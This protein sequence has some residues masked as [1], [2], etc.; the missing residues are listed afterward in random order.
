[1]PNCLKAVFAIAILLSFAAPARAKSG[2]SLVLRRAEKAV[3]IDGLIDAAWS[4]AD[5][6]SDFVELQPFYGKPPSRRTVAKIMASDEA[7]YCLIICYDDRSHI[8]HFAGKLDEFTGDA[9]S[10]MF[11][12]F[13]DNR[14]A[15]KFAVGASGSR[16]D[17]RLL[18][19][20][21]NRDYSWDGVWFSAARI[22]NWGYVVEM[23]IPFRSIQYD[24]RLAAW[25]LDFDRWIPGSNEDI[26]WNSYGENEGQRISKFGTLILNGCRPK[27]KGLNFELYP[28][29]A[30]RAT[31]LREGIYR[32]KPDAG[33]DLFYNPSQSLTFQLTANPDFAQIE[34]DPFNFNISR[35][36]SYF[37]E[38]RPFFTQGN[39]VFMPSGREQNSG[40]YRPLELFYSRRIGRNLPDGTEV[41][42]VVGAKAFG[43]IGGWEYGGFMAMTDHATYVEDGMRKTE[44]QALFGALRLKRQVLDNSSIGVLMVQKRTAT[45]FSGVL[46]IDGA[47]RAPAWQLSY[48]LARSVKNA[49]GDYASSVGLNVTKDDYMLGVRGRFIGN[50][51]DVGDVGYVPWIGTS[52]LTFFGGPRWYYETGAVRTL[53]LYTGASFTYKDPELATDRFGVLGFNMQF[54]SNWGCEITFVG[55]RAKDSGIRY[56]SYELDV[57]TWFN[58]TP[59]WNANVYG[60][61]AKTYNFSRDYLAFYTWEGAS[62]DWHVFNVLTLGTT[63][64]AFVEGNPKNEIQ[65]VTLNGRP[66]ISLTPLNDLNVR[67]YVDNVFDVASDRMQHVVAG[68]LFSYSFLPK[69]WIYLALNEVRDRSDEFDSNGILTPNRM[70]VTDRVG[71]F[72]MKYLYYF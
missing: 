53:F 69:S 71:V 22:Y 24:E 59:A 10:V 31:Y 13:G 25:G 66:Y 54:R 27:V 48:Q 56:D 35:Y 50:R 72:K 70:H 7:L 37:D 46:D 2:K 33:I 49:E 43:R 64:N 4:K 5:S 18:D 39:E 1:M 55:G 60:G 23:K 11:D 12:T 67:I 19:D 8:Q 63:M 15:Y 21:R 30:A 17:C 16:S 44:Q 62:V 26:Y 52:E 28:V 36:E 61:Y 57:S 47:F 41:P 14:T 6:V 65:D 51:F 42:L 68:F 9:T 20:G 34:A 32:V 40:F 45:D 29:A 58:V 38:R 3:A